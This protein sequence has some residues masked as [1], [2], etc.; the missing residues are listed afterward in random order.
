MSIDTYNISEDEL[1]QIIADMKKR[2]KDVISHPQIYSQFSDSE[3]VEFED[4]DVSDIERKK[5]E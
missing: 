1:N 2:D 4:L 5:T 3:T